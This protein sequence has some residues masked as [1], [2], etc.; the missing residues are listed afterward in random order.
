MLTV[1]ALRWIMSARLSK[2][3]S[4]LKRLARPL[5]TIPGLGL[6]LFAALLVFPLGKAG[7]GRLLG[8]F[9]SLILPFRLKETFSYDSVAGLC[10]WLTVFLIVSSK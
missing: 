4:S 7:F 9:S 1:G 6:F 5:E 10:S 2:Q 8:R 3:L